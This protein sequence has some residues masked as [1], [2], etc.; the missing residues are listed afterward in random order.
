M[1]RKVLWGQQEFVLDYQIKGNA[2]QG[3]KKFGLRPCYMG[4]KSI[5]SKQ[6]RKCQMDKI[7]EQ[8]RPFSNL[9]LA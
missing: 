3:Q 8:A 2:H 1:Q 4:R 5:S 9:E 7:S 6:D